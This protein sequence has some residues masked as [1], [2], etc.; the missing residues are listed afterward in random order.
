[1]ASTFERNQNIEAQ[2][3][4][5]EIQKI[6]SIVFSFQELSDVCLLVLHLEV[7]VHCFHF[8]SPM[9]QHGEFA[10]GVDSQN[11]DPEVVKLNRDLLNIHGILSSSLVPMKCRVSLLII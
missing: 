7:R 5:E 9:A 6:Q 2:L 1:V 8:L 4:K 10:P 3:L 11:P